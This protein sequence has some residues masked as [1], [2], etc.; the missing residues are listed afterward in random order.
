M[1]ILRKKAIRQATRSLSVFLPAERK[2]ELDRWI[3]GRD[4]ASKL[5]TADLV[6]V[7]FG[8]SGRTWLRVLLS[9]YFQ[10]MYGLRDGN[11]IGFDNLHRKNPSIPS[12]FFTHDNYLR[13]YTG[14]V[15]SKSDFYDKRVVLLVR[16]PK[17]VAVSQYFQWKHRMKKSKKVLN[18]YPAHGSDI[19]LFDF[20][21][22]PSCGLPKIIDFMNLWADESPR[23]K[24]L[25]IVRYEDMHSL[26]VDTFRS[27]V[28][29]LGA[30]SNDDELRGAIEYASADHMRKLEEKNV[31]WLSGG[32][33]KPG[34]KGDPNTYKV[35]R[36]KVDG[37]RDYFAAEELAAID[38]LVSSTLSG[39]LGFGSSPETQ[40]DL[41]RD[42]DSR[43]NQ[44]SPAPGSDASPNGRSPI[45]PT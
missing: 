14:N 38:N 33:L 29:F 24:N 25:L 41:S 35:R 10:Q 39:Y 20:V 17:D 31:F 22:D 11:L 34:K 1:N 2:R 44:I 32:R 18:Q 23:I 21:M 16:N 43:R 8:K 37:Y 6:V 40:T 3:R 9:R 7:S 19:S 26:P 4:E 12:I 15:S 27:V 5:S 45:Y 28:Q 30:P 13:D 36:A 42:S